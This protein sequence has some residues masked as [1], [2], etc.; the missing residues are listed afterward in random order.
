M[1]EF[2]ALLK[3]TEGEALM[4]FIEPIRSGEES[5]RSEGPSLLIIATALEGLFG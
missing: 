2:E 3:A 5:A 4:F 1:S